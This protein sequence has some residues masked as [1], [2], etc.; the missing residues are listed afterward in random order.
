MRSALIKKTN[1]RQMLPHSESENTIWADLINFDGT[2]SLKKCEQ[3]FKYQLSEL[4]FHKNLKY[5]T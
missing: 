1:G 3:L 4:I 2:A 5:K